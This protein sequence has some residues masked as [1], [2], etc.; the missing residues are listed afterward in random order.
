MIR[1]ERTIHFQHQTLG[2]MNNKAH[3]KQR[4]SLRQSLRELLR[5]RSS[6]PSARAID[7]VGSGILRRA[8]PPAAYL[9]QFSSVSHFSA[10]D[11]SR[12]QLG[13]NT[14]QTSRKH[15]TKV[16]TREGHAHPT[17]THP[18]LPATSLSQFSLNE[19]Y[20]QHGSVPRHSVYQNVINANISTVSRQASLST[21][22]TSQLRPSESTLRLR[23]S[24]SAL[25]ADPA[26]EDD[27]RVIGI[28]NTS[29]L[30][31]AES[32]LHSKSPSL[33][34]PTF[35]QRKATRDQKQSPLTLVEHF[36]SFCVLDTATIGCPVTATS[37]DLRYIFQ[38]GEQFFLNNQQ[39][40]GTSMDI[41]T[42][43]DALGNPV[44]HLVLFSPLIAPSSGRS[45]FIFAS[46]VDVTKFIEETASMP[47]LDTISEE[48][49]I[50]IVVTPPTYS[51]SAWPLLDH[52]LSTEELL[53]GCCIS[54]V[55]A[56]SKPVDSDI[57]LDLAA[58]EK[59][60]RVRQGWHY[61]NP[62]TTPSSRSTRSDI[63]NVDDVLDQFVADLQNLYSDF[64][65][66]GK[67]PLDQ[68]VYEI[69]NV[70]PRVFASREY[71]DGHLSHTPREIIETLSVR[72]S[73]SDAFSLPVTWGTPG[74]AKQLYCC[75]VF[76]QSNLT[77]ICFLVNSDL[78]RLW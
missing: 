9:P 65:L 45:R 68:D 59:R 23:E 57:W 24:R 63:S 21:I 47:E 36:R 42:G 18:L 61:D 60:P 4:K 31:A 62:S 17:E 8:D 73:G 10:S 20:I 74:E 78:P 56:N 16:P 72:L 32:F 5:L 39:C 14:S 58:S 12:F 50:E 19:A 64:F 26:L 28:S 37:S 69:C 29:R 34:E 1:L 30:P 6:R 38:I 44:T 67:S 52:E 25:T 7:S 40:Q 41:V 77:W 22:K 71:V 27:F 15:V 54:D 55:K 35:T 46:L 76:G 13:N 2:I 3:P 66:L 43:S 11:A 75:P 70:S 33:V 53:G 49:A 51:S 48:S